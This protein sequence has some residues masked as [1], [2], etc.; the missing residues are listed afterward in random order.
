M[1]SHCPVDCCAFVVVLVVHLRVRE[2]FN[3]TVKVSVSY[4]VIE[5]IYFYK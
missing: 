1:G 2:M 5:T 4:D 3:L